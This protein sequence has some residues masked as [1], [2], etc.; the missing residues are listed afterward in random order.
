M[1]SDC[2]GEHLMGCEPNWYQG[3]PSPYYTDSHKEFRKKCR[4]F[5]ETEMK[6]HVEDWIKSP[7][8]YP[9]SLHQRAYSAGLQ[10]ILFPKEFGGAREDTDYFHELILWDEMGRCSAQVLGQ[11]Q[12]N[13]MAIPPVL[14]HG[15]EEMKAAVLP[16]VVQ[17][18]KSISLMISEPQAG[19]DVAN[20]RT[21][22]VK[23]DGCYV[24]NGQKKWITGG[25]RADF[26][27]CAVRTGDPG[28]GGIS[29][30]LIP[31]SSPGI[32]IRKM[33]TQFDNTNGTAFVT[34]EDV[35]VPEGNLI[36][37]EGMGFMYL[38]YN[39]NHERFVIAVGACRAARNCYEE[40]IKYALKRKTFGKQLIEHQAIRLKL[41][42]MLRQI[43]AV[44]DS[45]ERVAYSL[46][47]GVPDLALGATCA[48]LKV[49]SSRCFEYC[50]REASQIFG[51]SSIVREGQGMLV[52]RLYRDVRQAAIPGGSE[53]ILLDFTIR[54]AVAKDL[55]K[56]K[57]AAKM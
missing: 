3:F 48:L 4:E 44:H 29:L 11:L 8:G 30:L 47:K 43:E 56:Q 55:K 26:F 39:F 14:L 51:G 45:C 57:K 27:T 12:I 24:V 37:D 25:H 38:M 9:A 2:F 54:Q 53:E 40:S 23:Q 20:L 32:T 28:F 21:T 49:N 18:E 16:A 22:A 31:S 46:S 10:G 7:E 42:E 41:A 17:G 36:G 5:V 13:S 19:S 35:K 1:Q 15:S 33:A 34:L 52:E 50:A 6:P